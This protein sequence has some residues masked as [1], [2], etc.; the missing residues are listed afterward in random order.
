[1][2]N[3]PHYD[4]LDEFGGRVIH[5]HDFR[6]GSDYKDMDVLVVGTSYSAEDIASHCYKYGCKSVTIS[7]RT[8]P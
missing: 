3:V 1:M 6:N 2:A 4:G 7:Y 8:N 5:S